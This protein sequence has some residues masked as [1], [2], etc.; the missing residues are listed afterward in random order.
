MPMNRA[1]I[2]A[3]LPYV[4][5]VAVLVAA[6]VAAAFLPPVWSLEPHEIHVIVHIDKPIQVQM[7]PPR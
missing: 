1:R 3:A 7:V 6:L 4:G 2:I 5:F